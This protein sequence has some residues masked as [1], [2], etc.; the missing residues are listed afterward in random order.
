M[1]KMKK[2]VMKSV[3]IDNELNVVNNLII[4]YL[5]VKKKK[6]GVEISEDVSVEM[7]PRINEASNTYRM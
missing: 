4:L 1:K 3:F 7:N 6:D 5:I 2:K